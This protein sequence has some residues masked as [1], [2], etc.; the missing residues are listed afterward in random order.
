MFDMIDI[1]TLANSII[2]INQNSSEDEKFS[3]IKNVVLIY[4]DAKNDSTKKDKLKTQIA[5]KALLKTAANIYGY[6]QH[7]TRHELKTNINGA[8]TKIIY[9]IGFEYDLNPDP[10]LL[11]VG[12]YAI[13]GSAK[14]SADQTDPDRIKNRK[15][16]GYLST[17][18][19]YNETTNRAYL[20]VPNARQITDIMLQSENYED[21]MKNLVLHDLEYPFIQ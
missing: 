9:W 21:F 15:S 4:E 5:F 8:D 14:T 13:E 12:V 16:T 19:K 17:I 18:S 7:E 11:H 2:N 3:F 20:E 10:N 6:P 1:K